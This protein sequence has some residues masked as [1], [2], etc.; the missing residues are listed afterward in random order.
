MSDLDLEQEVKL[1]SQKVDIMANEL[2]AA[3]KEISSIQ[4]ILGQLGGII[5]AEEK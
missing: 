3:T 2:Q 1:L 4:K 5:P